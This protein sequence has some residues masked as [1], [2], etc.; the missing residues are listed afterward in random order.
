MEKDGGDGKQSYNMVFFFFVCMC[1]C[2][3]CTCEAPMLQCTRRGQKAA[4]DVCPP[5]LCPNKVSL[6]L[7]AVYSRLTGS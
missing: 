6:L 2:D 3:V 5:L 4:L 7:L 1:V